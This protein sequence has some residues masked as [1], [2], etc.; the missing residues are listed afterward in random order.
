[1]RREHDMAVKVYDEVLKREVLV[2][3]VITP[4][5]MEDHPHDQVLNELKVEE[6][7]FDDEM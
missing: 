5:I 2:Q 7:D 4:E 3:T 1:M 6:G